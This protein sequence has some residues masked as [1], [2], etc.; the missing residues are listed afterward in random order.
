MTL[1]VPDR[2]SELVELSRQRILVL[3]GAMG[4]ALQDAAL[5]KWGES[6][7]KR[8][9]VGED[10]RW[11][12][13]QTKK[14]VAGLKDVL[15]ANP[16]PAGPPV[17]YEHWFE[18]LLNKAREKLGRPTKAVPTTQPAATQAAATTAPAQ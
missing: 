12:L 15:A 13:E 16:V 14:V 4:T 5:E 11:T 1:R 10:G 18:K 17:N 2:A 8:D 3:D 6:I 9:D 7:P